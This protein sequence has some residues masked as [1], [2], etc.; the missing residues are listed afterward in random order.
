MLRG[1]TNLVRA[2]QPLSF[3]NIGFF[4]K[5]FKVVDDPSQVSKLI[6]NEDGFCKIYEYKL[7]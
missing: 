7:G 6:F 4:S 3:K 2:Y 1:V 5:K